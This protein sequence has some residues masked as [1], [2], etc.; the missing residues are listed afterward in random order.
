MVWHTYYGDAGKAACYVC[1]HIDIYR[2]A[3]E[4]AHVKARAKGGS[5]E[6]RNLRPCCSHCNKSIGT[7]DLEEYKRK[8][9]L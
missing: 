4:V 3:F 6:V 1:K 9:G 2:D 5:D 8:Y 7:D